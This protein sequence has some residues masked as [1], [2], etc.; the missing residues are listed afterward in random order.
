MNTMRIVGLVMLLIA[1][2]V[3][4]QHEAQEEKQVQIQRSNQAAQDNSSMI[5]ATQDAVSLTGSAFANQGI[6]YGRMEG[7]EGDNDDFECRPIVTNNIIV[8]R[9]HP[10]SLV[11]SGSI[12]IDFGDGTTCDSTHV[13]KGKIIDSI[14]LVVVLKD[15]II[16]KSSEKITFQNYWRDSTQVDGMIS[17]NAATGSPT[18][19]SINGSRI[20]YHDGT[21]SSWTGSLVF[22]YHKNTIARIID[23]TGSWS[24]TTRHGITFSATIIETIEYKTG[25]FGHFGRFIP[26]SGKINVV[27]NGVTST[28]DYGSGTCDRVYTITTAGVT[29]EHRLS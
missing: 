15:R 20:R 9:S 24:G 4:C 1:F 28:I 5:A 22:T 8:D 17:V 29:T 23:V 10:D 11:I 18:I 12:I 3:S 26:V 2:V 6:A 25:C 16:F 21:I 19:V 27:T 14:M 13:R 7:E